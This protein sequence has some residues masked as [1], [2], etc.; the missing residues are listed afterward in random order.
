[1]V[2]LAQRG[3]AAKNERDLWKFLGGV[4]EF[5]ETMATALRREMLEEKQNWISPTFICKILSSTPTIHE[6]DRCTAIGWFTLDEMP[7]GLT[8]ISSEILKN[9]KTWLTTN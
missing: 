3:P 6:P 2:F 5:G 7:A 9:Y 4:V 8:S 1:M